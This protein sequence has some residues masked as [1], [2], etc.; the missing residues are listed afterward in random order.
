[1]V[2]FRQFS[3]GLVVGIVRRPDPSEPDAQQ[4]LRALIGE[5]AK[6]VN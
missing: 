5:R 2:Q 1:M 3:I 4:R 6:S